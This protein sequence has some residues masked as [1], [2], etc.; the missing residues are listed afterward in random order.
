MALDGG[1]EGTLDRV[2][3]A[4]T[5]G[6]GDAF[7]RVEVEVRVAVV[8]DGVQVV[9]PV[10]AV[11]DLPQPDRTRPVLQ[12]AVTADRT[13]HAAHGQVV[14]LAVQHALLEDGDFGRLG[15]GNH[16]ADDRRRT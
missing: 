2:S 14:E 5:A 4:H 10:V 15:A 8:G 7:G 11:P 3:R 16:S 12:L 1:R 6:A 9:L 13:G